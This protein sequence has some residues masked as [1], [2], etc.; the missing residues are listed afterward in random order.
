M[1]SI[2]YIGHARFYEALHIDPA[3]VGFGYTSAL[4]RGSGFILM[5]L[6]STVALWPLVFLLGR[7]AFSPR[8]DRG[9][10]TSMPAG[11]TSRVGQWLRNERRM[12]IVTLL[13]SFMIFAADTS[14]HSLVLLAEQQVLYLQATR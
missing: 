10:R 2:I 7:G 4:T 14:S 12:L 8:S 9:T 1:Y 13:I 11:D 6:L 3:S 5:D